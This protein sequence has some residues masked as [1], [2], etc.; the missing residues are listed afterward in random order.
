[1]KIVHSLAEAQFDRNSVVT[2]GT[3]DGVHLAHREIIREAMQRAKVREGR[4]VVITFDPHPKEVLGGRDQPVSM[5]STVEE[6]LARLDALGVNLLLLIRFTYDFSRLTARDFYQRYVI[7]GIGVSEVV[8]GYDHMFG[9]DRGGGI[10][11]LV[12]MGRE[13]DFSVF[14][15]HPVTVA[16]EVV[17]S[18]LVRKTLLSGEVERARLF[19][20]YPYAVNGKVVKGDGRGRSLG[21]PTANIEPLSTRKIIPRNGVYLVALRLGSEAHYGMMNIGVRPTFTNGIQETIEVH[22]IDFAGDIY[23]RGVEVRFLSR[24]RD[25]QKFGS[26]E[27]LVAQ[28]H[29][30]LRKSKEYIAAI[31]YNSKQDAATDI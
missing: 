17:S 27:E 15:V 2:V 20:G 26:R 12:R 4:S 5:L 24:I 3:F 14:A 7:E 16:G 21:Y 23:G 18:S 22:I 13:F 9:R 10:E 30:D 6:K 28:L 8:L 25:E 29:R 1:M 11:Q 19:L 31:A